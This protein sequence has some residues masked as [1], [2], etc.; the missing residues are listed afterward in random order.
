MAYRVGNYE[1]E[2]PKLFEKQII[3]S[4][5]WDG[6]EDSYEMR[7]SRN[8][9]FIKRKEYRMIRCTRCVMPETWAGIKFDEEG[10]CNICR[11]SE[12]KVNIDWIKR[13]IWL[14][15]ILEKYR[16]YAK[17]RSNKYD[18][19]VGYSGGKDTTYTLWAMVKKYKMKPLVVTADHGF[20]LSTKPEYNLM[21]IPKMLDCDHLRFIPG[22]GLRNALCRRGSEVNGDFCWHCHNGVAT[23]T[24]RIS[25]QWDVPLVVWG[26]P[27]AAYGTDGAYTYDD[28]EEPDKK[29]YQRM[30]L[31]EVTPEIM[32]PPGYELADLLPMIWPKGEFELKA[33][34][35]GN[36]EPWDQR[37]NVEIITRELGWKHQEMEGT[38]VDWDKVDCPYE[39]V[40]DWQKFTKR[41][42][43]RTT[44]QAS[45]DIRDGLMTREEALKLVENLDGKRPKALDQFL[46]ETDMTEDEFNE[47]TRRHIV[48]RSE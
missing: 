43:G 39:P 5:R 11:E 30:A 26:E 6:N 19:I 46:K 45:K 37:K 34:Y 3:P 4:R 40:R 8:W 21:D 25:K 32:V 20:R 2:Q 12:K 42:F 17:Q 22:N 44:F 41:G 28:F 18:C 31:A 10:V 15:E 9:A 24:A 33:I 23:L 27:T 16:K 29:H 1:I 38:Y 48:P 13:Q 7:N 36:F 35:L 47:I 14:F